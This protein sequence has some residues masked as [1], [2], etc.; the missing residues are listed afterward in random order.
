MFIRVSKQK[1]GKEVLL[2]V[3]HIWKIEVEY[4]V[5]SKERTF[6]RIKM[7]Q[8]AST[9]NAVRLYRIY[10]GKQAV[11]VLARPN[12]PASKVLDDIYREASGTT[13]GDAV[14]HQPQQVNN[15]K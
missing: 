14:E 8:V 11:R 12:D 1:N 10:N 6:S 2:N 3:H 13:I 9:A 5:L 15:G 7:D 4:G